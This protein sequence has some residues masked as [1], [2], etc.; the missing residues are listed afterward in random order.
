MSRSIIRETLF[1]NFL[2]L[3]C[4]ILHRN[5]REY[6]AFNTT[7]THT[8]KVSTP[9]YSFDLH[10]LPSPTSRRAVLTVNGWRLANDYG[11]RDWPVQRLDARV[12]TLQILRVPKPREFA[13]YVVL[14]HLAGLYDCLLYVDR[15]VPR[16]RVDAFISMCDVSDDGLYVTERNSTHLLLLRGGTHRIDWESLR[17]CHD[18]EIVNVTAVSLRRMDRRLLNGAMCTRRVA[19]RL[20]CVQALSRWKI[21]RAGV[22]LGLVSLLMPH[23]IFGTWRSKPL[24]DLHEAK[25]RREGLMAAALGCAISLLGAG[26][27]VCRD[28]FCQMWMGEGLVTRKGWI[29][30]GNAAVTFGKVNVM[31]KMD[32]LCLEWFSLFLLYI[33]LRFCARSVSTATFP[34]RLVRMPA[35]IRSLALQGCFSYQTE[36]CLP[37]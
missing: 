29:S 30:A 36:V 25:S 7:A 33:T 19:N 18:E 12:N 28:G 2:L 17:T 10:A 6:N 26:F 14:D 37:D 13:K 15:D 11:L 4:Y 31:L 23:A 1:A 3:L 9:F 22:F 8:T 32:N 27:R 16:L 35:K 24:K 34:W 5:V 20:E 21:R